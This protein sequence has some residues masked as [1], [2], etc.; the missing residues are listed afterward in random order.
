MQD[1]QDRAAPAAL[2]GYNALVM[3]FTFARL[4]VMAILCSSAAPVAAMENRPE[5][6]RT[7]DWRGLPL[8]QA[9]DQLA[10]DTTIPY[11]IGKSV[12]PE[13]MDR[14]IRLFASHLNGRQ[15]YRWAARLA[16]LEAVIREGVALIALPQELPRIWRLTGGPAAEPSG[17]QERLQAI[18]RQR[19][20]INWVD[21]PLSGVARDI[22]ATF[23]IDVLFHPRIR[24][25]QP[26][27][28]LELSEASFDALQSAIEEQLKARALL[29]DGALWV[30][31][32][33][34]EWDQP[35]ARPSPH[36]SVLPAEVR[37]GPATGPLDQFVVLD[38]SVRSWQDVCDRLSRAGEVDCRVSPPDA[39][40]SGPLEARGTLGEVLEAARLLGRL[41]WQLAPRSPQGA[42]RLE[43]RP[44]PEE[45]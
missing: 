36:A 40:F 6:V 18:S 27:I 43:I 3:R 15:A 26:L 8:R 31:P 22:S 11:V 23:G 42:A 35:A 14:R 29:V 16:G 45:R 24:S 20:N 13:A 9:L 12:P 28:H 5:A 41:T 30:V 1:K 44:E 34:M 38:R 37:P 17:W 2:S 7:V 32:A 10:R 33:D 19:A 39:P 25:E 21:A 4:I